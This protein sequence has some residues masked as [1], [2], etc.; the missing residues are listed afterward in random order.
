MSIFMRKYRM[1]GDECDTLQ[2]VFLHP[3]SN[4]KVSRLPPTL[5]NKENVLVLCF[6]FSK[7][8]FFIKIVASSRGMT[9]R[10]L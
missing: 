9:M 3:K 10:K 6:F 1:F 2:G 7:I 4:K 8:N 5:Q